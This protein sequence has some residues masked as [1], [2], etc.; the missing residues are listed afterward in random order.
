MKK[1]YVVTYYYNNGEHWEDEIHC[2]IPEKVYFNL[3]DALKQD[4]FIQ[5]ED[6]LD[7]YIY[8]SVEHKFEEEEDEDEVNL[9]PDE[10]YEYRIYEC[11]VQEK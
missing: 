3:E 10:Y 1:A 5:A 8:R 11:E 4:K 2:E 9:H 7:E 6:D